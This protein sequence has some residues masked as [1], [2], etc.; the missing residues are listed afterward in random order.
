MFEPNRYWLILCQD[1]CRAERLRVEGTL[2]VE[3]VRCR[4]PSTHVTAAQ[5]PQAKRGQ[6]LNPSRSFREM[7]D[8]I[9]GDISVLCLRAAVGNIL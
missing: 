5:L 8:Y 1:A 7:N 3:G 6:T 9:L 2:L 4:S